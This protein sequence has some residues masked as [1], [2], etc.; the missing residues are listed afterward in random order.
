MSLYTP[1]RISKPR[2]QMVPAEAVEATYK[3][4][5]TRTFWGVT[6][7][8]TLYYVCRMTLGVV[9]QPR[10]ASSSTA[11]LPITAISAALWRPV[12]PSLRW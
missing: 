9:K 7:V 5:R 6:V 3:R 8:Y 1:F 2:A 10:W 12:S 4:L 11:S